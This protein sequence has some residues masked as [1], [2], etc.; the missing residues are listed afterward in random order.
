MNILEIIIS[1]AISTGFVAVFISHYYNKKLKTHEMK[2]NKYLLLIEELAKLTSNTPDFGKLLPLLN[3]ALLFASDDV[4]K[5]ILK[6]NKVFCEKRNQ[7]KENKFQISAD[8]LKPLV[9]SIRKDLYLKSSS[10]DEEGLA[11]FQKP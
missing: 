3:E 9:V 4:V 10:I 6:F 2:L 8:D 11:F 7:A 1:T 5:E